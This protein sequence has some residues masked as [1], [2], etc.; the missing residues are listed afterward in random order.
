MPK[1]ELKEVEVLARNIFRSS[2]SETLNLFF[3][4]TPWPIGVYWRGWVGLSIDFCKYNS[5]SEIYETI[6]HELSHY[7]AAPNP[8]HGA[9][10]LEAARSMGIDGSQAAKLN[11]KFYSYYK[12]FVDDSMLKKTSLRWICTV[13]RD[14]AKRTDAGE[15][16]I[17]DYKKYAQFPYIDGYEITDL[18]QQYGNKAW[19]AR[20]MAGLVL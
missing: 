8:G 20:L 2:G 11:Q 13:L 6:M 4:S 9:D 14:V 16:G 10:F 12:A 19:E 3:Y 17:T 18:N 7:M 5:T 15:K 1:M